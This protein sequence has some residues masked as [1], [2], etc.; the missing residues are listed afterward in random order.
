MEEYRNEAKKRYYE[1]QRLE[2]EEKQYIET[3]KQRIA[4]EKYRME[5]HHMTHVLHSW[6]TLHTIFPISIESIMNL[7]NLIKEHVILFQQ[8]Q[9]MEEIQERMVHLIEILNTQHEVILHS[10]E[11]VKR[12]QD[13]MTELIHLCNIDVTIE[14]MD[15]SQDEF[16]AHQIQEEL[17]NDIHHQLDPTFDEIYLHDQIEIPIQIPIQNQY[18]NR[19]KPIC[20]YT[21]RIGLTVPELKQIA[22][23]HHLSHKG[24]KEE[25]CKRLAD[26]DLV[27]IV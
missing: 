13:R 10:V 25:L 14:S 22:I 6:D 19:N 17:F 5:E 8:Y 7:C 12:I 23:V 26:A 4:D 15:V 20:S 1:K 16:I 21:K 11:D 27:T 18:E 3:E 9:R 24:S 2:E